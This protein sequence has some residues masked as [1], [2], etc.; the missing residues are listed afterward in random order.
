MILEQQSTGVQWK[1]SQHLACS[2]LVLYHLYCQSEPL[3]TKSAL[4]T[5]PLWD[6]V[7]ITFWRVVWRILPFLLGSPLGFQISCIMDR[8]LMETGCLST[9]CWASQ[10]KTATAALCFPLLFPSCVCQLDSNLI[11]VLSVWT[12]LKPNSAYYQ[13]LSLNETTF[14]PIS[15][16]F[17]GKSIWITWHVASLCHLDWSPTLY[18]RGS[19]QLTETSW[20]LCNLPPCCPSLPCLIKT[21]NSCT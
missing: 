17:R 15:P 20:A 2:A 19:L 14:P 10:L 8:I 21:D 4:Q 12:P 13:Q 18:L 7:P 1:G 16:R 11:S 5:G 6:N 3:L 9:A